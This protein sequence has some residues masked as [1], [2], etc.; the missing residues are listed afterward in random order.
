MWP[1]AC[2]VTLQSRGLQDASSRWHACPVRCGKR[3]GMRL[4]Y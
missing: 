3:R 1:H 2:P 4:C